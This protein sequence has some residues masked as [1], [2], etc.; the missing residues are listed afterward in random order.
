VGSSSIL[1]T[2]SKNRTY[3]HHRCPVCRQSQLRLSQF[4]TIQTVPKD[5]VPNS[6]SRLLARCLL[7]AWCLAIFSCRRVV[8]LTFSLAFSLLIARLHFSHSLVVLRTHHA[9]QSLILTVVT[10]PKE[11]SNSA[12]R[13][14]E[15]KFSGRS[16]HSSRMDG[17]RGDS[18]ELS[19]FAVLVVLW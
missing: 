13:Q 9:H 16:R 4:S 2:R 8:V 19:G 12:R 6:Q 15:L 7:F 11:N 5:S 3:F 18:E 1:S 10:M 14:Y 17:G